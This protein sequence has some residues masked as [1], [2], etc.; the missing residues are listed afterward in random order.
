MY[1]KNSSHSNCFF[2]IPKSLILK[3]KKALGYRFLSF[4]ADRQYDSIKAWLSC[5]SVMTAPPPFRQ[6]PRYSESF[7]FS[8]K[9]RDSETGL[10]YFGSRYYSGDL[11]I[12]LSVDPQSDKYP[13]LSPYVYC[14]DNSVQCVDPNGEEVWIP[15][16]DAKGNVIYTAEDGDNY[17]TFITQFD[18]TDANGKLRGREIFAKW[19]TKSQTK[20]YN[21]YYYTQSFGDWLNKY[22]F[23]LPKVGSCRQMFL[24]TVDGKNSEAFEKLF[25]K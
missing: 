11:S 3:N 24:F 7:T 17:G 13:S 18:C 10:S 14:A 4:C 12:W 21:F 6:H 9:E 22:D 20:S 2:V 5:S 8:A 25:R 16:L 19:F 1:L 23:R 15:G